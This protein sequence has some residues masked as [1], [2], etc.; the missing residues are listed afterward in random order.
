MKYGICQTCNTHYR[1]TVAREG[2]GFVLVCDC[3]PAAALP[4]DE[5][6][7]VRIEPPAR[8]TKTVAARCD[9][10]ERG[11]IQ[12]RAR[13]AGLDVSGFIRQQL[14]LSP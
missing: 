11:D 6:P 8:R 12:R 10:R 5:M 14:G 1:R 7:T 9:N 3:N 13:A 2:G 4:A